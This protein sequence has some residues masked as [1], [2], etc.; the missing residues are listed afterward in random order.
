MLFPSLFAYWYKNSVIDP[1]LWTD[2]TSSVCCVWLPARAAVFINKSRVTNWVY[3]HPLVSISGR[4][5]LS[6]QHT[7][8]PNTVAVCGVDFAFVR[9]REQ[10]KWRPRFRHLV[11]KFCGKLG[12]MKLRG[13][14]I[15]RSIRSDFN[16][17]SWHD[18]EGRGVDGGGPWEVR[19]GGRRLP[20]ELSWCLGRWLERLFMRKS[21]FWQS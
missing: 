18:C 11:C 21:G 10:I 15:N 19:E 16:W 14:D 8:V 4:V 17:Q 6:H 1:R 2:Q 9:R 13:N 12:E 7:H 20:N 5:C 3:L